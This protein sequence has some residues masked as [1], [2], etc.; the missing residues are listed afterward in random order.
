MRSWPNGSANALP[1]FKH[2]IV[3][4]AERLFSGES[5]AS[6]GG[7]NDG[8]SPGNAGDCRAYHKMAAAGWSVVY[9]YR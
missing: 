6:H 9:F 1:E 2:R 4:K 8:Q 3:A 7:L 5:R